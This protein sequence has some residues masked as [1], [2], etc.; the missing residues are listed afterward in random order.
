[1]ALVVLT[2]AG[3]PDQKLLAR[4]LKDVEDRVLARGEPFVQIIDS[5][6]GEMPDAVQ[7]AMIAAHQR[8]MDRAY[9]NLCLGE[10][11]VVSP[12]IRGAMVAVFWV[13]KP[14]YPYTFVE[15]FPAALAWAQARLNEGEPKD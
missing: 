9:R 8:K 13:A 11:Y 6:R 10:A 1:V 14:P 15:N 3:K 4:H 7:R 5:S 12:N 2:Y